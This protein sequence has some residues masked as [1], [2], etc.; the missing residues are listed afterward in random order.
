MQRCFKNV[1]NVTLNLCQRKL[2]FSTFS[3]HKQYRRFLYAE[4]SGKGLPQGLDLNF[5]SLAVQAPD[6]GSYKV[7]GITTEAACAIVKF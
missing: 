2:G 7:G 6:C 5:V 4:I 3:V 1:G